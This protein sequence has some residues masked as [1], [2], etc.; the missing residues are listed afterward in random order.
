MLDI[1]LVR[2]QAELVKKN[3]SKKN[4]DPKVV[5]EVI[6]LDKKWRAALK[7]ME[8]L[9]HTRNVVSEEINKAKKAKDEKAAQKKIAEMRTVADNIKKQE[10]KVKTFLEKRD[11]VLLKLSNIIHPDVPPGKD[12]S[13]NVE[14]KKIGKIPKFD[15]PVKN[16]VELLEELNLVDFDASATTTGNGFY[17]LKGE[18]ALLNQAL[19]RFAVDFMC[20]QGYTYI[21]PPLMLRK[22]VLSAAI[23]TGEF[24]QTIYSIDGEDLSL[25]GTSEHALLGM[26]AG[27]A[28]EMKELPLKYFS[29][30]MC[31]RKEVG[32]HGI[33]EKGLWRTHQFNKV[34]QFIFCHP[35]ESDKM[36]MELLKNSEGILKELQLPYRVIELCTGDLAAWKYRS[37]D[38]E[39]WRPTLDKYGEIMSLSN[40]TDYQARKL[41][42]KVNDKDGRKMVHTL[43][44]TALATSR[45]MVAILENNQTKKGTVKVPK[46]LVP[47]M[48]GIT[49]MGKR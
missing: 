11:I 36:F 20:K 2:E 24:G 21:E 35:D 47:Y 19:I 9:K 49:E 33:N 5:D 14:L 31:F 37:Y 3:E 26:H 40:C 44:N 22:D 1:N 32:A 41:G 43:N 8:T 30:S 7:E 12:D 38:V 4:K 16:H 29:Y 6:S 17:F 15:F 39:V 18:L 23:D 25:I 28:F 27:K 45:I 34:E 13:E 10:E 42:I 46:V 48:Q